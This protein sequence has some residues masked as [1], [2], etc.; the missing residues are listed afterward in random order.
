MPLS[1]DRNIRLSGRDELAMNFLTVRLNRH[2]RTSD[3]KHYGRHAEHSFASAVRMFFSDCTGSILLETVIATIIF[4]VV[5]VAVLAGL[6]NAYYSGDK[7]E[8]QSVA[9]NTVRNQ[10]E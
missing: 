3:V 9:E 7:T 4:S 5:R 6:S 10:M 1:Q 2:L 8:T